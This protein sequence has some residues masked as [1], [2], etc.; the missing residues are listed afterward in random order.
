MSHACVPLS[1]SG[2]TLSLY[3]PGPTLSLSGPTFSFYRL[4]PTLSL[5]RPGPT[6]SL[7]GP[8]P[9]LSCRNLGYILNDSKQICLG[10]WQSQTLKTKNT[11]VLF[12][13]KKLCWL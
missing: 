11:V 12:F 2:T 4:G 5:Y 1:L 9:T 7:Y 13:T 3:R 8:G 10:I 6:L